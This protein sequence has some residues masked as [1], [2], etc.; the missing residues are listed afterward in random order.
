MN[1]KK[2]LIVSSLF[3]SFFSQARST[4]LMLEEQI[5]ELINLESTIFKNIDENESI[6]TL[7]QIRIRARLY[8]GVQIPLI[9]KAEI[10]AEIELFWVKK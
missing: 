4:T 3:M 8:A 9:S 10:R 5:G 1:Y 2:I 7:S 6:F